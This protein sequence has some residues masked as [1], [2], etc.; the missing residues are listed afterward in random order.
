MGFSLL[1]H[2]KTNSA[3]SGGYKNFSPPAGGIESS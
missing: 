2:E 3:V 1:N